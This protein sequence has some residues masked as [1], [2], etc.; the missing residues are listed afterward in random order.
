MSLI[1]S[2]IYMCDSIDNYI[3][4]H[5]EKD[6]ISEMGKLQIAACISEA[7][8]NSK[9][10]FNKMESKAK[11]NLKIISDAWVD[12]FGRILIEG[13]YSKDVDRI[14]ENCYFVIFNYDRC[15]E[16][17]VIEIIRQTYHIDYEHAHKIVS[18]F[19]IIHPYGS[20]G[21]LPSSLNGSDGSVPFGLTIDGGLDVWRTIKNIRT[22]TEQVKDD[23]VSS[24]I[25]DYVNKC[26]NVIFLGFGFH[27]QN[28][29]FL[30][31]HC[32]SRFR[33][34]Y[35]TGMGFHKA[36]SDE[37]NRRIISIYC[38]SEDYDNFN[39]SI[40]FEVGVSSLELISMHRQN[41]SSP[42]PM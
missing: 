27:P 13:V 30:K 26:Q 15:F 20:L 28:V 17:S 2:G 32:D 39:G 29:S 12:S 34:I 22:Y 9:I 21:D 41:I 8:K 37:I 36:V 25:C 33:K 42:S 6:S 19:N 3:D 1:S 18:N 40:N 35:A 23:E 7:E 5:S 16:Y 11:L 24:K 10:N 31:S 4:I 14:G 38:D